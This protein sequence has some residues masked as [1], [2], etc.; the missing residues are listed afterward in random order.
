MEELINK[1]PIGKENAIH[2]ST[3]A[4]LLGVSSEMAKRMV[5]EARQNGYEILSGKQGYW[6]AK[7]DTERAL[8]IRMFSMSAISRLKTARTIRTPLNNSDGQM[9]LFDGFINASEEAT[10]H[11]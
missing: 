11:E 8:C 6:L 7:D 9:S 5:R 4:A 2:Q 1:I 3:L 10:T